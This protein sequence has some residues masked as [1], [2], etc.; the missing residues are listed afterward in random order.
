MEELLVSRIPLFAPLPE[1]ER[2][3][4][5]ELLQPVELPPGEIL[6]REGETGLCFYFIIE[7][8]VEIVKAM[9]TENE[10]LLGVRGPGEYLGEMSLFNPDGLRTASVRALTMALLLEMS[11]ADFDV[12]LHRS[13]HL[14]HELLR[15]MSLRLR[16]ANESTLRDL[17]EKNVQLAQAYQELL[18]AQAQIIQKEKLERELELAREIQL[19]YLPRELPRPKGFDFGARMLAARA[20]GGDFYDFILLETDQIG[21]VVADVS[22]KGVPASIMMALSRSILRAEAAPGGP[23]GKT[24]LAMNEHL[25]EMNESGMFVTLL[26]GVLDPHNG[27]FSY[28]RAGHEF[29]LLFESDGTGIVLP[30]R[31]GQPVGILPDPEMDEQI[32]RL[33][34]GNT[35]LIFTDGLPDAMN[36]QGEFFGQERLLEAARKW[37]GVP[38]QEI[39]DGLIGAIKEFQGANAQFDDMTLVVIKAV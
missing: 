31:R 5:S 11:H 9:D 8:Q 17:S 30:H 3:N 28:T 15:V 7:G 33:H 25:L 38:A 10:R 37:L 12:I 21:I 27:E 22:D 35:L 29:P 24:V 19:Q 36:S 2:R 4:L 1:E 18:A 14:A 34:P 26:Y 16:D 6:L 23:P 39:C 32:I 20:V 13:P